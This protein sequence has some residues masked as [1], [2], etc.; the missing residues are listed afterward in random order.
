MSASTEI[1]EELQQP[2]DSLTYSTFVKKFNEEYSESLNEQ[3]KKLLG[4]YIS[5]FSDNALQLKVFL[6]DEIA[7]LKEALEK[8][9][10]TSEVKE[11]KPL[12]EKI[13][14]VY[15]ILDKT[16]EKEIDTETL[17]IVLNTQQLI[18]EIWENV[19]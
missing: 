17:E 19:D 3:Q 16:K 11:N 13:E 15:S 18:E 1:K 12:K 5:S 7:R 9:K 10:E 14:K 6:N 4:H 8:S 2:I